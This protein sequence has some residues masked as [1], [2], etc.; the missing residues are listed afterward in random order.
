MARVRIPAVLGPTGITPAAPTFTAVPGSFLPIVAG[1]SSAD[2]VLVG[3][4]VGDPALAGAT[5][6]VDVPD[7]DVTGNALDAQKI[8]TRYP[9]HWLVA[10]HVIPGT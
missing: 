10:N 6:Q 4:P 8:K 3:A 7:E 1:K 5:Y 9:N 2:G